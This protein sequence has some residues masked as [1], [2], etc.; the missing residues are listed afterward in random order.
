MEKHGCHF[1]RWYRDNGAFLNE[2][3][4]YVCQRGAAV[5]QHGLVKSERQVRQPVY[6]SGFRSQ[7][8]LLYSW[9]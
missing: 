9:S 8:G 6:L 5:F 2:A 1:D 4:N 3:Q 7:G